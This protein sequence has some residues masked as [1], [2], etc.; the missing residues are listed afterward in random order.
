MTD[1]DTWGRRVGVVVSRSE[2]IVE[3]VRNSLENPLPH[4]SIRRAMAKDLFYNPGTATDVAVDWLCH[5]LAPR[6]LHNAMASSRGP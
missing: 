6:V 5:N 3:V 4:P 1:T 2:D